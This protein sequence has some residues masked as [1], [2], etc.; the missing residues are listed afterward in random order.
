[1]RPRTGRHSGFTLVEL[2]VVIGIV[3]ILAAL[4]LAVV[5]QVRQ[6][7]AR[8]TCANNLKQIGLAIHQHH[9]TF[10]VLPSNGGWDGRQQIQD[11]DGNSIYVTVHD[12]TLPFPWVLGVGDPNRLPWDQTGSWAF[13]LLPFLEQQNMYR[14]R[15]W[16]DPVKIYCCPARRLPQALPPKDDAYGDYE[17]GGWPWGKTDYAANALAIPNRPVCLF[18]A[19]FTDG[20]ANT[21][22]CGEKAMSPQNYATGTWYWDEPFFTGGSGGTQRGFGT[23]PGEGTAVVRDS[24]DMGYAFRYNWGS[25]HPGGAQFVFGDGSIRTLAYG[26]ASAEVFALLTPSGGEVVPESP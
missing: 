5:Q 21:I 22:L 13:A 10:G 8:A 1:M 16:V 6:A 19:R 12:A 7:A 2:L 26:T 24:P 18:L 23:Q 4:T 15:A 11:V 9:D 20:T 14:E 25:P 3:A 17:G